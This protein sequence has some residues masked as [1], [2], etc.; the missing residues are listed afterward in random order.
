MFGEDTYRI[1]K[2]PDREK[3]AELG[4]EAT[5]EE[6][7]QA[8]KDEFERKRMQLHFTRFNHLAAKMKSFT[9]KD[10]EDATKMTNAWWQPRFNPIPQSRDLEVW[11]ESI[12]KELGKATTDPEIGQLMVKIATVTPTWEELD[13][14]LWP[15]NQPAFKQMVYKSTLA[16]NKIIAD[17]AGSL[18]VK[19]DVK[20]FNYRRHKELGEDP[21][22]Q[23][24]FWQLLFFVK[25]DLFHEHNF[26]RR[27]KQQEFVALEIQGTHWQALEVFQNKWDTLRIEL[28][29]EHLSSNYLDED[30]Y[31]EKKY[32]EN[33]MKCKDF[34]SH[35]KHY[36]DQVYYSEDL[37]KPKLDKS[38]ATLIPFV[39]KFLERKHHER[40]ENSINSRMTTTLL[41]GLAFMA[42][43]GKGDAQ[44]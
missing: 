37:G 5:H 2:K 28:D 36:E 4:R 30:L 11:I 22:R 15:W 18:K 38:V 26:D 29:G 34:E 43:K 20:L 35:Y 13:S 33:V 39:R 21:D 9:Q 41:P 42:T 12:V 17:T 24:N 3:P 40:N 16:M 1:P 31:I 27:K 14:N 25:E 44:V 23:F 10:R 6:R 32:F 8:L 7:K 19:I